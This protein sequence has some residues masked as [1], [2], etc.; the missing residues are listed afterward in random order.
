MS[1]KHY[2]P[3][4]ASERAA[5]KKKAAE[6]KKMTRAQKKRASTMSK[7]AKVPVSK[8]TLRSAGASL[9]KAVNR[10]KK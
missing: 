5:M 2:K 7:P 4:T 9:R 6:E 8:K 10:K 3:A 1:V